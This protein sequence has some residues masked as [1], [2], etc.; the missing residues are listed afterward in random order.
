M[1]LVS[2]DFIKTIIEKYNIDL[3]SRYLLVLPPSV[4]NCGID[5]VEKFFRQVNYLANDKNLKIL[6]KPHRND[7]IHKLFEVS[8]LKDVIDYNSVKQ[9]FSEFFFLIPNIERIISV[10][11][12]SL[13]FADYSKLT[14]F[15]PKDRKLFRKKFLDQTC[16]LDSIRVNYSKI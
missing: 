4:E 16:Y 11:S 5:F 3:E 15:V 6:I 10:P 14:V 12:S 2:S 1:E 9:L 7:N 13:T 8:K